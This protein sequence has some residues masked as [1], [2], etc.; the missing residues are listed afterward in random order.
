M[1]F[2][3]YHRHPAYKS[4]APGDTACKADSDG[5]PKR[6]PVTASAF[7]LIGKE[8]ERGWE[9]AD[10]ISTLLPSLIRYQ[11]NTGTAPN[12]WAR[13]RS[14]ASA[15]SDSREWSRSVTLS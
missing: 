8:T 4:L 13:M 11:R 10:D 12:C 3:Q 2:S 15:W 6:Y 9:Q 7:H 14:T 1:V 5:L